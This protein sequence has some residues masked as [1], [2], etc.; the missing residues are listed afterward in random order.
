MGSNKSGKQVSFQKKLW[1]A[2][3]SASAAYIKK[4]TTD[5]TPNKGNPGS[6]TIISHD[7]G[8]LV[9]IS[10]RTVRELLKISHLYL[11]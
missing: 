2:H 4:I 8:P 7:T 9:G 5:P 3:A 6:L 10:R 1:Q 11:L